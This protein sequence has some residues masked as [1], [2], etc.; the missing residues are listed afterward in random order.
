M[1]LQYIGD[2]DR[3]GP[4][5]GSY[6]RNPDRD[7]PSEPPLKFFELYQTRNDQIVASSDNWMND[8]D[9]VGNSAVEGIVPSDVG[10]E[11]VEAW[12]WVVNY[13]HTATPETF[14]TLINY[15]SEGD[16]SSITTGDSFDQNIGSSDRRWKL[17]ITEQVQNAPPIA[18][19]VM[20]IQI[21]NGGGT[22]WIDGGGVITR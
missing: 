1:K 13:S 12:V 14:S 22:F 5:L 20:G 9:F 17:D 11:V 3:I 18:G 16:T 7:T 10:E 19:E 15:A 2:Q 8:F 21:S 6:V 4:I